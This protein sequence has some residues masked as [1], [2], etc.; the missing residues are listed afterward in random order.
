MGNVS[1]IP[2]TDVRC[3]NGEPVNLVVGESEDSR[4]SRPQC[5]GNDHSAEDIALGDVYALFDAEPLTT[6]EVGNRLDVAKS[7]GR[8]KL[9]KLYEQDKLRNKTIGT[10]SVI[11]WR[12]TR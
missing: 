2:G 6:V 4:K 11:W 12:N 3:I 9:D 1:H 8:A 7:A 10:G 5:E